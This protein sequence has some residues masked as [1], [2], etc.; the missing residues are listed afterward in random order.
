MNKLET[1]LKYQGRPLK[2]IKH[3]GRVA[4]YQAEDPYGYEVVIIRD[5]KAREK[6]GKFYPDHE[7]YPV[8]EARGIL[9]LDLPA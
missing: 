9:R 5:E 1:E 4:L 2:Q 3:E 7:T 8:S 6:F